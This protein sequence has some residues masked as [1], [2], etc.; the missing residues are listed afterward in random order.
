MNSIQVVKRLRF[1][2][3]VSVEAILVAKQKKQHAQIIKPCLS[4][5]ITS[6]ITSRRFFT[7]LTI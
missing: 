4:N 6:P 1:E 7:A 3:G 2:G 5:F